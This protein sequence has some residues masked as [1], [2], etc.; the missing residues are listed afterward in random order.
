NPF[1]NAATRRATTGRRLSLVNFYLCSCHRLDT[2]DRQSEPS[3]NLAFDT[4]KFS[5]ERTS[6]D[7]DQRR[8]LPSQKNKRLLPHGP[9]QGV[10]DCCIV[11]T[12]SSWGQGPIVRSTTWPNFLNN[13]L[14]YQ[15]VLSMRRMQ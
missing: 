12:R 15:F 5:Y 2:P 1:E 13:S 7:L 3:G 9:I 10:A 11:R 4:S 14:T 8:R 6:V